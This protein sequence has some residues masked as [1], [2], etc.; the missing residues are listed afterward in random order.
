MNLYHV[1]PARYAAAADNRPP[2]RT[3]IRGMPPTMASYDQQK[4]QKGT[5]LL[6]WCLVPMVVTVLVL[7]PWERP[8]A[9]TR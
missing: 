3:A 5:N 8:V 4:R 1:N 9:A 2:A 6:A 7:S